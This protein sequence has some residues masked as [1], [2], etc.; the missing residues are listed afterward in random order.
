MTSTRFFDTIFV[1]ENATRKG[2]KKGRRERQEKSTKNYASI[3]Q[4]LVNSLDSRQ[5]SQLSARDTR[6][7]IA[8]SSSKSKKTENKKRQSESNTSR[9]NGE[10]FHSTVNVIEIM[11]LTIVVSGGDNTTESML[12]NETTETKNS[13]FHSV[14]RVG[15]K[16]SNEFGPT[17]IN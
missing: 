5:L 7:V 3:N 16:L 11:P 17:K 2:R 13:V 15:T 4:L 6:F 1:S 14:A 12:R 8:T 10:S 9:R